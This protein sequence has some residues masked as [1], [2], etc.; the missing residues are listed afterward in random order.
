M[1]RILGQGGQ[2]TVY[3]GMLADEKIVEVKKSKVIDE[4]KLQE[5]I[6]EVIILSQINHRNVVKLIGCCLETG[7]LLLVYEQIPNGMLFQYVNGQIEEFL[8]TWDMRLRIVTEVVGAFF[9]LHS[10]ASSPIYH[11]YI[12]FTSILLDEK[13]RAKVADFGTLR[14]ITIDQTHLTTLMHSTFG[15]LDPEYFQS[16]QFI[17]KSDVYSFGVV[18]AKLLTEEIIAVANLVKRCL[19]L[20][21][22]K[23]PTM[24]EVA[25]ELE[26]IQ[27]L[28]KAPNFEQN[29]EELKY[30]K[31]GKGWNDCRMQFSK[32][33]QYHDKQ[34]MGGTSQ[35]GHPRKT[36]VGLLNKGQ[37]FVST[38]SFNLQ[39]AL[40]NKSNAEAVQG[41]GYN[42]KLLSQLLADKG[43]TGEPIIEQ[44]M[45]IDLR[46]TDESHNSMSID[47]EKVEQVSILTIRDMLADFKKDIIS[48]LKGHLPEISDFQRRQVPQQR[49]LRFGAAVEGSERVE[50]AMGEHTV[51]GQRRAVIE[52]SHSQVDPKVA[53]LG[54][55]EGAKAI[56]EARGR[57]PMGVGVGVGFR[58]VAEIEKVEDNS[59]GGLFLLEV[60][61]EMGVDGGE[62]DGEERRAGGK[63]GF[64]RFGRRGFGRGELRGKWGRKRRE[65]EDDGD[66]KREGEGE[67]K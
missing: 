46:R 47:V 39:G 15:Y 4:G 67:I 24:K 18:L 28:Q 9:Y 14:S 49:P 31:E 58:L 6:N 36:S 33:K 60:V 38:D 32:L 64:R 55:P 51:P 45:D 37:S 30:G 16:S 66:G 40:A 11:R 50:L 63:K 2:G 62:G 44:L 56:G 61:A 65:E 53:I 20:N 35:G 5:F 26:T 59:V 54:N 23:R 25:M 52:L 19:D 27:M 57:V 17:E 10:A 7:V 22:K 41:N 21:G 12:K 3:K 1:N 43:E 34:K 29:C 42:L 48:C 8:R 13:Y